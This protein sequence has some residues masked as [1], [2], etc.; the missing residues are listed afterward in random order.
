[1][2]RGGAVTPE[3]MIAFLNSIECEPSRVTPHVL[4]AN[5]VEIR[6]MIGDL[7]RL[8]EIITAISAHASAHRFVDTTGT[9]Q[10]GDMDR[11]RD[12]LE[13]T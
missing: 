2:D 5:L 13:L 4:K 9:G 8:R 12:I 3:L 1:M 7:V 10:S 11:I 6:D